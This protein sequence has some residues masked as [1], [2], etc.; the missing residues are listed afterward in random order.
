M[1]KVSG[2]YKMFSMISGIQLKTNFMKKIA[3]IAVIL[4]IAVCFLQGTG[5]KNEMILTELIGQRIDIMNDFYTGNITFEE[6]SEQLSQVEA[7][8]LLEEDCTNLKKY[9]RTDIEKI[10][11]YQVRSVDFSYEAEN[12]LC[13]L[14]TIA[15]TIEETEPQSGQTEKAQKQEFCTD[16]STIAQDCGNGYRLVQFF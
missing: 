3:V 9:F 14:V 15:W 4:F 11:R 2:K 7:E 10:H 6:A 13:G 5:N 8:N 16:Y 1:K 12:L